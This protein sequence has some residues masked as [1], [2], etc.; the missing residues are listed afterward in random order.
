MND[1][2]RVSKRR[3]VVGLVLLLLVSAVG[4]SALAFNGDRSNE[5]PISTPKVRTPSPSRPVQVMP[6]TPPELASFYDQQV[7][8]E[9]CKQEADHDC[10]T[11]R[12][13]LDYDRP[14][15]KSIDLALLRVPAEDPEVKVGSLVVN[16]GGPG[17]Q[18]TTYAA[19]AGTV[20]G[21]ALLSHFDVVGFDPRGVG[22]SAAIDCLS[23]NQLDIY[24][25]ADAAPTTSADLAVLR[26]QLRGLGKGCVNLSGALASHVTTVEAARDM[27]ILRSV[28]EQ[29]RLDFFGASYGTKLG[30]TY[31]QLFPKNVGRMVLDGAIDLSIGPRA[32]ALQQAVGFETA[33][34]AYVGN[35]VDSGNCFLGK[36]VDA[37][38]VRIQKF[39]VDAEDAPLTTNGDRKLT[40]GSA[41]YGL[42]TPLYD[43]QYWNILSLALK[44]AFGGNGTSMLSLADAYT[45]RSPDGYLSNTIEANYA[46][47][48][49]DDPRSTPLDQ[50]RKEVPAFV[51]ASST[52]GRVFAYGLASCSE[53][54]ARS[55]ITAP[56]NDAA[57]AAPLL[58]IGTTRDPA[59]PLRWAVALADQLSSAV[60]VT[61][62]G[63]GHTGYRAD[64]DCV[65][66]TVEDYL[67]DG[68]VP[69][70]DVECPAP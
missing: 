65:D 9:P 42:I 68:T 14:T 24:L 5:N 13:P 21:D 57:G 10:A 63:D 64:N 50:I 27:D 22:E 69:A 55:T 53:S 44:Q 39:L 47:N 36:T 33:L 16:P 31:A 15:G 6:E 29:P 61:R 52:F 3:A 28:L 35:C 48:C 40:S 4:I 67:V 2:R 46:I 17:G 51:K 56:D 1:L 49:L 25:A 38:I 70:R 12:V 19:A 30:A 26:R 59:T 7:A 23:D 32:L 58:V 66:K 37:G 62:D 20:F 11:L 43:R 18:G 45:S 8:W 54:V 60:L 41:F 34:R